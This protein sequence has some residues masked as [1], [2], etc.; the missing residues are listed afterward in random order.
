MRVGY[1]D[2]RWHTVYH[3]RRNVPS[4]GRFFL[5][6]VAGKLPGRGAPIFL[7]DRR[8][9]ALKA[10]IRELES[11]VAAPGPA[12]E[13]PDRIRVP[14][15]RRRG[16]RVPVLEMQVHR[17][18]ARPGRSAVA[19][20]W[21]STGPAPGTTP[22]SLCWWMCRTRTGTL[23]EV[24]KKVNSSSAAPRP[25]LPPLSRIGAWATPLRS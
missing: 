22:G 10:Q 13:M 2:D 20:L 25:W 18:P 24:R 14:W 11:A 15:P 3:M 19:G 1:E 23:F 8:E 4:G 17:V 7:T 21:L 6:P 16:R 9:K 5:K 12:P